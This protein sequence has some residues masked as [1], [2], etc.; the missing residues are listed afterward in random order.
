MSER[1]I[2]DREQLHTALAYAAQRFQEALPS[3]LDIVE[4]LHKRGF[5]DESISNYQIGYAPGSW[6]FLTNATQSEESEFTFDH[7]REAGLVVEPTTAGKSRYDFYRNRIMFPIY[8]SQGKV[9][10]FTARRDP[11]G[12][13]ETAKYIN[14]RET[15]AYK[16]KETLFGLSH[17]L[18]ALREKGFLNVSEIFITEGAPDV[19]L[20][21]QQGIYNTLAPCG[22]A[23]TAEQVALVKRWFPNATQVLCFDGDNAGNEATARKIGDIFGSDVEVAL[24]PAGK[25]LAD[26][27]TSYADPLSIIKAQ[28]K[29]DLA[30]LWDYYS[31]DHNLESTAQKMALLLIYIDFQKDVKR[32]GSLLNMTKQPI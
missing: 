20:A 10:S 12:S 23:Y 16:K 27:V 17:A 29:S 13:E 6:S 1:G 3:R 5:S 11:F 8:D 18:K 30:F 28:Q 25:D 22:T 4:Y 31:T 15:G 9:V 2:F 19:I 14:G 21:H 26:V 7:L 32:T 24:L